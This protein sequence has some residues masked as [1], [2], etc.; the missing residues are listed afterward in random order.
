MLS[1]P[2]VQIGGEEHSTHTIKSKDLPPAKSHLR[3]FP[4]LFSQPGFEVQQKA[5]DVSPVP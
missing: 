1:A 3:F 5:K 2:P 4:S